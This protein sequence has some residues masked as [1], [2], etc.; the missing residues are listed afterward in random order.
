MTPIPVILDTDIGT[1]IDDTWAL[2]QLLRSPELDLR[3]VVASTGDVAYRARLAARL[4]ERADRADVPV[5]LGVPSASRPRPQGLWVAG[6][7]LPD[8]PGEV[9]DD[10]VAALVET[11]RALEGVTVIGIGPLPTV[12]A[13]LDLAPDLAE[14]ARYVGMQGSLREAPGRPDLEYNVMEDPGACRQVLAAPWEVTLTPLDSCGIVRLSGEQLARLR[15][16]ESPLTQAVLENFAIWAEHVRWPHGADAHSSILFD[17][18][19]VHLAHSTRFLVMEELGVR[20]TGEGRTVL[21]PACR[22]LRCATGWQD[23]PGFTEELVGRL[24]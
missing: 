3:L 11:A 12:A 13:A 18:V 20:V 24:A 21:D 14:R 10:G 16:S 23:L 4:L 1:D 2:A 6:Y 19:A 5:A 9:R 8:Y 7:E 17:T 22:P 15:G